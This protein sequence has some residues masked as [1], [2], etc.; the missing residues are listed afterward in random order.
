M[1][2]EDKAVILCVDD[3]EIPLMLRRLVLEK[4]GYKVVTAGSAAEAWDIVTSRHID[5]VLSDHLM[6]GSTGAELAR[7]IK[8]RLPGLPVILHSGV[9]EVP[10]DAGYA[11]LFLSKVVG[12]I[13]LCE[14][15][16]AVLAE[17]GTRK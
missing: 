8:T 4:A 17:A 1:M 7:E 11:D 9:N 5:L 13:I 10:S 16:S 6:P 3:E 15:V 2:L 14:Q 12:P